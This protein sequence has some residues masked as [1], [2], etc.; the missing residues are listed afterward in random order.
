MVP[1]SQKTE[2][3]VLEQQG[4]ATSEGFYC[5]LFKNAYVTYVY[6]DSGNL[7]IKTLYVPGSRL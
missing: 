4:K 3:G 1:V 7:I 5:Q 6:C 2:A